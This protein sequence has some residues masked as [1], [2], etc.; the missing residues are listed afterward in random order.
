LI[1]PRHRARGERGRGH[2]PRTAAGRNGTGGLA[3][4]GGRLTAAVEAEYDRAGAVGGEWQHRVLEDAARQR[5]RIG[6]VRPGV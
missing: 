5:L 3:T 6:V 4:A 2:S 1:V